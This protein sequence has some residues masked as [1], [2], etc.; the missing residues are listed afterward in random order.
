MKKH[1]I[2]K[3][4]TKN[5]NDVIGIHTFTVCDMSSPEARSLEKRI[6]ALSDQRQRYIKKGIFN[7]SNAAFIKQQTDRLL[8]Q[9]HARFLVQ[10]VVVKNLTTT[11]GR[12]VPMQRLANITT[13]TGIVN[14]CAL[15]TGTATPNVADTQLAAETYR[16]LVTSSTAVSNV[17]Y[18]DC[19]FTMAE[20]TGTFQ[21]YGFFIDGNAGA[22]SGVLWN[23]FLDAV[24]KSGTQSLT[25][26]SIITLA[27]A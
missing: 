21:E 4:A 11:V 6:V 9:M 26:Q 8:A 23:R 12:T 17:A 19:Y 20:V 14:Y 22:N 10:Q 3:D 1:I 27:S 24:T 13:N 2:L 7:E 16:K 5:Q 18:L 15:G 25:V